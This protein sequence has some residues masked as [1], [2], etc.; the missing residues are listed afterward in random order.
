[1][2]PLIN[3][4][5]VLLELTRNAEDPAAILIL[6]PGIGVGNLMRLLQTAAWEASTKLTDAGMTMPP[7]T[8][9]M[10]TAVT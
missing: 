10:A 4:V 9:V 3:S 7:T 5:A 1:M 2:S 6:S 8:G